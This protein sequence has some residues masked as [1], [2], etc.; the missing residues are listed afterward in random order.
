MNKVITGIIFSALLVALPGCNES[1][2]LRSLRSQPPQPAPV[3]VKVQRALADPGAGATGYVGTVSSSRTATLTAPVSGTLVEGPVREGSRVS[4][5][6]TVARIS[7]QAVSSAS[8]AAATRLRQAEDGWARVQQV[9]ASGTITEVEYIKVKTQLEEARAADAAARAALE[10]CTL[11]APFS[12]VAEKVWLSPGVETVLAE[13]VVRI[14]SLGSL[15]IHFSLPENEFPRHAA[16]ESLTVEIPAL[17]YSCAGVLRSKGVTASP[18]SHSYDCTVTLRSPVRGLMP[19]MVC[20]VFLSDTESDEIVIPSSAV[21]TDL[22]GR[23]VWTATDGVV[24]KR[25]VTVGGY[26]GQGIVIAEGLSADDLVIIEGSRKVST[27]MHV[28]TQE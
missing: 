10:K 22:E 3:V 12:G 26:S 7:S 11:K 6:Q 16:G 5:G 24:E 14:V 28:Q 15:E 8:E 25:R 19:G 2:R 4:K 9:Y 18:L 1:G 13:P 20:K 23:Y 27:G 21:M 17:D